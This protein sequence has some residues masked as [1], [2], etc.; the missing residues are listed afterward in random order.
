MTYTKKFRLGSFDAGFGKRSVLLHFTP[1]PVSSGQTK[2]QAAW[3]PRARLVITH[4]K[5]WRE[6]ITTGLTQSHEKQNGKKPSPICARSICKRLTSHRSLEPFLDSDVCPKYAS[7][8]REKWRF[9]H[10]L[11]NLE[12]LVF[13]LLCLILRLIFV[14]GSARASEIYNTHS[15]MAEVDCKW[16]WPR[17]GF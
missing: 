1:E 16:I 15:H 13:L 5:K 12:P 6:L 8:Y 7:R 11:T 4:K 17:W 2:K 14:H 10:I 9:C 3:R